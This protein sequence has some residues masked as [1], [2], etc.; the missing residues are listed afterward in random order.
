MLLRI[1]LD[2]LP[3]KA[4]AIDHRMPMLN[5][6]MAPRPAGPAISP[7]GALLKRL[8]CMLKKSNAAFV[9]LTPLR[10]RSNSE[11]PRSSSSAG[12]RLLNAD[13]RISW[14]ID[15][16]RVVRNRLSFFCGYPIASARHR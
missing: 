5:C 9:F 15:S 11:T 7:A 14:L 3:T 13:R 16:A 6:P 1:D 8:E 2:Q 10:L 4:G 12:T